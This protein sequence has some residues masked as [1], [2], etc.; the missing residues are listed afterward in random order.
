MRKEVFVEA[1]KTRFPICSQE[2]ILKWTDFAGEC[3]ERGK[4]VDFV[5]EPDTDRAVGKW[6]DSNCAGFLLVQKKHGIQAAAEI[7]GLSSLVC[8]YP[9]EMEAAAVFLTSGGSRERIPG[10]IREGEQHGVPVFP[11]LGQEEIMRM[12]IMATAKEYVR[13]FDPFR[14]DM[15]PYVPKDGA[16]LYFSRVYTLEDGKIAGFSNRAG[17]KPLEDMKG[18][19]FVERTCRDDPKGS[20]VGVHIHNFVHPGKEP[21]R[22]VQIDE[23]ALVC[24][25]ALTHQPTEIL[26]GEFFYGE[27]MGWRG[28]DLTSEIASDEEETH[29]PGLSL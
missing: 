2:D 22:N 13:K 8:L 18:D 27:V 4:Y 11:K 12:E 15:E 19:D 26:K 14:E 5:V 16:A 7:C 28:E 17:H 3:V 24:M 9:S 29:M 21:G 6:L 25:G 23:F 10:M 1:V 20:V